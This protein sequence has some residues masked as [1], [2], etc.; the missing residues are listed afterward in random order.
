MSGKRVLAVI[1]G[2]RSVEHEVSLVSGRTVAESADHERYE[3]VP[4]LIDRDGRWYTGEAGTLL[5][6]ERPSPPGTRVLAPG[7][8][9]EKRLLTP[10]GEPASPPLEVAFPIVHGSG[11]EDGLLQGVLETAQIPYVGAGV[12]AS[13]VCM[14]KVL[15]KRLLAAA[16]LPVVPWETVGIDEWPAKRGEVLARLGSLGLPVFVKPANGGSSVGVRKAATPEKLNEALDLALSLDV[17]ALVER[18]VDAREIECAVLG[19]R[20]PEC[21]S[22]CEIVPGKE[23]YDYEAKYG[24]AGSE[25][26]V[27]ARLDAALA[28]E[29]RRLA[30]AAYAALGVEGMARVDLLLEKESGRYYLNELNTLPGFTSISVYPQAWKETGLPLPRLVDR[31]VELALERAAEREVLRTRWRPDD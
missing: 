4:V 7:D 21:A 2:G 5:Q 22:P 14:H 20:R 24:D 10:S 17:E 19:N 8:P 31:L 29:A 3:L 13:S 25:V 15:A 1:F 28:E 11:G 16:G 26:H 30:L 23:F 12:L 6:T 18:S 9:S 27:P